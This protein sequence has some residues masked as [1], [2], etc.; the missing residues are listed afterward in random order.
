MRRLDEVHIEQ[1]I[2]PRLERG[3]MQALLALKPDLT[4][5]EALA[6][7]DYL[8]CYRDYLDCLRR[9]DSRNDRRLGLRHVRWGS[10]T[11]SL[12]ENPRQGSLPLPKRS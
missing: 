1:V 9:R 6:F 7:F 4:V 10:E 11:E 2:G 5:V 8:P 12:R 3:T